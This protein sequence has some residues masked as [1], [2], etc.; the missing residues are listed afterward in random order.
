M[1]DRRPQWRD[2]AIVPGFELGAGVTGAATSGL[3]IAVSTVID[4]W[5]FPV[6]RR[7]AAGRGSPYQR[8]PAAPAVARGAGGA[9]PDRTAGPPYSRAQVA[10]GWPP[11]TQTATG[12]DQ[13]KAHTQPSRMA[14][15][16][17]RA[18]SSWGEDVRLR[19]GEMKQWY[20][21]QLGLAATLH[22]RVGDLDDEHLGQELDRG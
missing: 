9:D 1:V 16:R 14:A 19:S 4:R 20:V 15:N 22:L 8:V 17:R 10:P 3:G 12:S 13:E 5:W 11:D 6:P 7:C 21:V 2:I 18:W